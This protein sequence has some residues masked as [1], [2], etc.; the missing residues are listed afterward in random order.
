MS[1]PL[2]Q[3]RRVPQFQICSLPHMAVTMFDGVEKMRFDRTDCDSQPCA[4]FFVRQ[5]VCL[6]QK[7]DLAAQL[8]ES[9]DSLRMHSE[10]LRDSIL[11]LAQPLFYNLRWSGNLHTVLDLPG[12]SLQPERGPLFCNAEAERSRHRLAPGQIFRRTHIPAPGRI[13]H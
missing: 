10:S 1:I 4:D 7:V 9:G 2:I 8:T 11:L 12:F 5:P 13:W 3:V 6:T